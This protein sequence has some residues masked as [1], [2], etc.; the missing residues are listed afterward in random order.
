[1]AYTLKA[2]GIAT[3]LVMCVAVDEDGSTIKE[4]VSPTVD[5]AKTLETGV[6]A[7]IGT[8][9]WKSVSRSYFQTLAN[10]TYDFYGITFGATKPAFDSGN[11]H[12]FS[13]Y[14]VC[15]GAGTRSGNQD[16][17]IQAGQVSRRILSISATDHQLIFNAANVGTTTIPSDGTTKFSMGGSFVN[18]GNVK[19]YYGLESGSLAQDGTTQ[20]DAGYGGNGQTIL[21]IGGDRTSGGKTPGK[22]HLVAM[23]QAELS[24]SD[25]QAL[26]T[27]WV[28]TLFDAGGGGIV[29]TSAAFRHIAGIGR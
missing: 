12:P 23:F 28:G 29:G 25:F 11:T 13:V 22:W 7:S 4:F 1:M 2:S 16:D 10:G 9:S 27:D 26:H 18:S 15:A 20:T 6:A 8:S 5:A 14:A 21:S 24:L 3:S 17:M 19:L